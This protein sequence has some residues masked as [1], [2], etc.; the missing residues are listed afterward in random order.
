[1]DRSLTRHK[2]AKI[3]EPLSS[4]SS[5]VAT[6]SASIQNC[7][8]CSEDFRS[9]EDN[10]DCNGVSDIRDFA[11][12]SEP[13]SFDFIMYSSVRRRLLGKCGATGSKQDPEGTYR[14]HENCEKND[15]GCGHTPSIRQRIQKIHDATPSI[16][17]QE[18]ISLAVG[19]IQT[20]YWY[21]V[22]REPSIDDQLSRLFFPLSVSI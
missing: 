16:L 1:M 21:S 11:T 6:T 12:R 4:E 13:S 18:G 5:H 3:L 8:I 9:T 14:E 20:K 7:V 22:P 19:R 2:A 17:H 15:S 10:I